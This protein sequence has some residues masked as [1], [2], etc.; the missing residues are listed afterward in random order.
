MKIIE[1][2]ENNMLS[3]KLILMNNR[4]F[5]VS[6]ILF[7]M[8]IL[9]RNSYTSLNIHK[10]KNKELIKIIKLPFQEVILNINKVL[11]INKL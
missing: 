4:V 6:N 3:V 5:I 8:Q 10:D 2:Q 9:K 11:M 7:R 1:I